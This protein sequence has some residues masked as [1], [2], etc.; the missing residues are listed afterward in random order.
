MLEMEARAK[1]WSSPDLHTNEK[2]Y[3]RT[4]WSYHYLFFQRIRCTHSHSIC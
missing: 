2:N 1:C 4:R 3:V